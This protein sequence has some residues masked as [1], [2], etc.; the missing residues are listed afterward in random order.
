LREQAWL[1]I[2]MKPL[3]RADCKGLCPQCGATL[4]LESCACETERIDPRLELLK[5][6]L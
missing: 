6:L 1:A 4:N 5:D 2:P 3:C